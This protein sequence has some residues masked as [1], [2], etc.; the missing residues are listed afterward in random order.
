[1]LK[2]IKKALRTVG[3]VSDVGSAITDG[4]ERIGNDFIQTLDDSADELFDDV[5]KAINESEF[6]DS[7]VEEDKEELFENTD[8]NAASFGDTSDPEEYIYA[9][10]QSDPQKT[11]EELLSEI[12][13]LRSEI[14][15]LKKLKSEESRILAEI[16]D[17]CAL[18]PDVPV[19]SLPD[20]VWESVKNGAPLA[21][22]F[23]LYERKTAAEAKRIAQI[24]SKNAS[25]AA[26]IAGTDAAGEYFSPEDVKRMS[27][28][29]VH[30][31][32]SKIK[33]SMKKWM[34]K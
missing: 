15:R 14:A 22:S 28:A 34:Q 9:E 16:G 10:T 31:N 5:A 32:Y 13:S 27:Q 33:E 2:L 18:F 25:R 24:N 11:V 26:G 29:E 8:S 12:D 17:F 7:S 3:K 20:E 1:M 6:D 19:E 23:A 30:A 21:A 4:I